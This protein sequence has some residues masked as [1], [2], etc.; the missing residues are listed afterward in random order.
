MTHGVP[1]NLYLFFFRVL[2]F[3]PFSVLVLSFLFFFFLSFLLSLSFV[4]VL[5]LIFDFLFYFIF[6][7]LPLRV[8]L[9]SAASY[10]D[11]WNGTPRCSLLS[12]TDPSYRSRDPTIPCTA[13]SNENEVPERARANR[14]LSPPVVSHER[15]A[16]VGRADC[17]R[18]EPSTPTRE[19]S[20]RSAPHHPPPLGPGKLSGPLPIP[21]WSACALGPGSRSVE[22]YHIFV[23]FLSLRCCCRCRCPQH[24]RRSYASRFSHCNTRVREP[25]ALIDIWH[26]FHR[27]IMHAVENW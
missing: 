17:S 15:P 26:S 2:C 1:D 20:S 22:L 11:R 25:D 23:F 6:G 7:F 16:I 18:V 5:F 14:W 12:T 3:S 8:R 4:S 19:R 27:R 9:R 21:S 10:G 13:R 24:P